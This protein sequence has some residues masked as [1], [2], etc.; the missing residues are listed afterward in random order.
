MPYQTAINSL[1]Q[2][3]MPALS[4]YNELFTADNQVRPDW[5]T[6]FSSLQQLGYGELKNRNV[7]ILRL[8][9]ENGVAY[10]IYHDSSGQNR[11]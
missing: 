5:E 8:L 3:Y 2:D 4:S 6:F 7:D 1:L 9:K 11:P 10:N